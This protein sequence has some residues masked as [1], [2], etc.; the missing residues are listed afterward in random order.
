MGPKD[1]F[2]ARKKRETTVTM[3]IMIKAL[4]IYLAC[5]QDEFLSFFNFGMQTYLLYNGV[6]IIPAGHVDVSRAR[7]R[8]EA[9]QEQQ[10]SEIQPGNNK[11]KTQSGTHHYVARWLHPNW[12]YRKQMTGT[13]LWFSK[14]HQDLLLYCCNVVSLVKRSIF[15]QKVNHKNLKVSPQTHN[16]HAVCQVMLSLTQPGKSHMMQDN[17]IN[18]KCQLFIKTLCNTC[19]I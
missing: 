1:L 14:S 18:I 12:Y 6:I 16:D 7:R 13:R 3:F 8:E 10:I 2:W 15:N 4:N 11:E 5:Y 17:A 9:K 19:E